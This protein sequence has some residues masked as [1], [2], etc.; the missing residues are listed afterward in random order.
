MAQSLK[1]SK[2]SETEHD[3][4]KTVIAVDGKTSE[5]SKDSY[6]KKSPLQIRKGVKNITRRLELLQGL[7]GII[8]PLLYVRPN[9]LPQR[10]PLPPH[11][12]QY[13]ATTV[14]RACRRYC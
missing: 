13:S 10:Q 12:R 9:N 7:T 3:V 8:M 11:R 5:G 1:E 2:T 14:C 6:H 4:S